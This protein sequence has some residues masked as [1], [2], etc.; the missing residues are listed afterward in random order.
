MRR[1]FLM[2]GQSN[3]CDRGYANEL[4][5]FPNANRMF[6]YSRIN[7]VGTAAEIGTH[8]VW[9]PATGVIDQA[10]ATSGMVGALALAFMNRMCDLYP[11]D[12]IGVVPRSSPGTSIDAFAKWNRNSGEYGMGLERM[13]WALDE[14]PVPAEISGF[15]W[16]QGEQDSYTSAAASSWSQK[17][18]NLVSNVRVDLQKLDLPTVFVKLGDDV[19]TGCTYWNTVRQQQAWMT[20]RGLKMVTIDDVTPLS[21]KTHYPTAGYLQI[22]VRMADAMPTL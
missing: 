22:G 20:M 17:F 15:L 12:E 19:P 21:D 2:M 9:T 3:M 8:G 18:C 7:P 6:V 10:G 5:V 16:W 1:L 14:C 13:W 11:D 4:P